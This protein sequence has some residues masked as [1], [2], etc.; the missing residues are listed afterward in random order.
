[1]RMLRNLA[2]TAV[3]IA[4]LSGQSGL[5]LAAEK[6][7]KELEEVSDTEK[8]KWARATKVSVTD[9]I[10]TAMAHTPGQVIE[11]A[12]HSIEGRLLF[13][14]EVVTKDGKVVELFVDP[15]TGKLVE[16]GDRK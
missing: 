15:Q 5:T 1:M 2:A 16:L 13:E 12:L 10:R 9:A 3:L 7:V 4:G 6:N 8:V 14:V 11:A